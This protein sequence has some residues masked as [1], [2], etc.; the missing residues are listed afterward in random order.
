MI[1]VLS[2][3][4]WTTIQD[5]GRYRLSHLGISAGGAA[6]P[7][8]LRLANLLVE[9]PPHAA[10]IEM[11]AIGGK[12]RFQKAVTFALM[13]GDF[14]PTLNGQRI[15]IGQSFLAE[16]GSVLE[17]SQARKGIRAYLA[18]AGGIITPMI[19]GSRS[20]LGLEKLQA[21]DLIPVGE[22]KTKSFWRTSFELCLAPSQILRFTEGAD[23]ELFSADAHQRL[24]SETFIVSPQSNRQGIRLQTSLEGSLDL[25]ERLT[26]GVCWGTLQVPPSGKPIILMNDLQTTGGYAQIAQVIKADFSGLGQCR[27]GCGLRFEKI[28]LEEAW[29]EAVA[30]EERLKASLE[31]L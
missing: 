25:E 28:S 23:W 11:T 14:A 27:P 31:R 8:S 12:F 3:G 4:A 6:D 10:A 1:E 18:V 30:L 22:S 19:L 20:S 21:G 5:Q 15:A 16:S 29:A 26:E 13:G 9:N 24:T 17:L 7:I 2:P